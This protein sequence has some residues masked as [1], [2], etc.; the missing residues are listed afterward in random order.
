[1][2]PS[3][4]NNA[5][6]RRTPPSARTPARSRA[7]PS[8]S[9]SATPTTASPLAM[10]GSHNACCSALPASR[11]AIGASTALPRKSNAVAFV[12][13]VHQGPRRACRAGQGPAATAR[14]QGPV[15]AVQGRLR[16]NRSH[17]L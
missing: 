5:L 7:R 1:M 3:S 4:T 13:Y 12:P 6:P 17:E 2:A 16:D 9:V 8:A 14:V 11:S 15:L 10:R